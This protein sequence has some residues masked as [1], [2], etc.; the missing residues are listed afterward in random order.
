MSGLQVDV[1]ACIRDDRYDSS[2]NDLVEAMLLPATFGSQLFDF[3]V[4]LLKDI[5]L[6]IA[7][8]IH[9]P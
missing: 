8:S 4:N 5:H 1:N 2:K 9:S 6:L 3:P 7:I